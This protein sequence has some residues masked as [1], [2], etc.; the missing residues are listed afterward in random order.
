MSRTDPPTYQTKVVVRSKSQGRQRKIAA[1]PLWW[2]A[3]HEDVTVVAGHLR[4]LQD[5]PDTWE[6]QTPNGTWQPGDP[7]RYLGWTGLVP[8]RPTWTKNV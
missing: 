4:P 2:H 7:R 8:C 3:E 6:F 1:M 5:V